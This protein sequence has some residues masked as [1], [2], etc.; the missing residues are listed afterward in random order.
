[1]VILIDA[2]NTAIKIAP[3]Q[4]GRI[5]SILTTPHTDFKSIISDFAAKQDII[6][7][8]A[9]CSVVRFNPS[10]LEILEDIAP[11]FEVGP[12]N[13]LPFK[14]A[15]KSAT[16]GADRLALV[17][18]SMEYRDQNRL[19]IDLGT[20]ITYDLITQENIYLGGA[21]SPGLNLRFKSLNDYTD[22]LPLL[23]PEN[24][25]FS[26]GSSTVE[27]IQSGVINGAAYEIDQFITETSRQYNNLTTLITGGN[28]RLLTKRLKNR[29]FAPPNLVLHG[30]KTL[31]EINQSN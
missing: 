9:L 26:V 15:Y 19:I 18:A 10:N 29:F 7:G 17:A 6:D 11:L 20:C 24:I 2:G 5:G 23:K 3:L 4:H 14:N 28:S 1:M 30:I 16:I 8:I 13:R 31:Y 22:R 21:I 12:G 25:D 27:S